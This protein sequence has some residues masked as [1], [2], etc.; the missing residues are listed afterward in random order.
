MS[1]R[2]AEKAVQTPDWLCGLLPQLSIMMSVLLT[3]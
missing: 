2:F 1:I 3:E